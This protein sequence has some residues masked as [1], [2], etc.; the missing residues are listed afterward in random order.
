MYV[1][2]VE[3][4]THES[5]FEAFL[6][7]VR[8]QASDS[9]QQESDCHVFDVCVSPDRDNYVLLYE[10]YSDRDAFDAHLES[11]HFRDFDSTVAEWVGDKKVTT[12]EK[13]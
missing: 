8:R 11:A 5:N 12:L 1:V 10:V 7:R 2:I 4:T 3:F 6:A 13:V 9:L